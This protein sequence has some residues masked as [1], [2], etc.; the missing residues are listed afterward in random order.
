MVNDAWNSLITLP[1]TAGHTYCQ[2]AVGS[3][4]SPGAFQDL[5]VNNWRSTSSS[6]RSGISTGSLRGRS[7]SSSIPASRGGKKVVRS[8]SACL[9]LSLMVVLSALSNSKTLS[10]KKP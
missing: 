8:S 10:N 2:T 5:A 9:N 4:S 3:P 1:L 6:I 7:P